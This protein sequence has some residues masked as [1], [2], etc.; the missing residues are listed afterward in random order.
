[1]NG[2]SNDVETGTKSASERQL[3]A[4]AKSCTQKSG[5]V[6]AAGAKSLIQRELQRTPH[7]TGE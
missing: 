2:K 4:A 7:K 5:S 1:M 3:R 6:L